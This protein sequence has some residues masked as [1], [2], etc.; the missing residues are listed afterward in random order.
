MLRRGAASRCCC[1]ATGRRSRR[2]RPLHRRSSTPRT[3][4]RGVRWDSG[5]RVRPPPPPRRLGAS[6]RGAIVGGRAG[7]GGRGGA[8]SNLAAAAPAA[9]L[10][11]GRRP[12]ASSG[13]GRRPTAAPLPG[14]A[15]RPPPPQRRRWRR[16][17]L[18]GCVH[19]ALAAV[20]RRC[21]PELQLYRAALS[22]A[23]SGSS[24]WRWRRRRGGC[25]RA[26]LRASRRRGSAALGC[27]SI[28]VELVTSSGGGGG[29]AGR[30][31][32]ATATTRRRRRRRRRAGGGCERPSS[33][34]W[35]REP[36]SAMA[37]DDLWVLSTDRRLGGPS[38]SRGRS[39]RRVVLRDARGQAA[40]R[41]PLQ[42]TLGDGG[43][44]R[45]ERRRRLGQLTCCR[46]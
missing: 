44:A 18:L 30:R 1:A 27:P 11:R 34:L 35:G 17:P 31:S 21:V 39:A 8:A 41:Q 5:R 26:S 19:P 29:G 42:R 25:C 37:V 46:T 4:R 10:C 16:S 33:R 13:R 38:S 15:R 32:G 14:A 3:P 23:V 40:R 20:A 2:R 22:A 24:T 45:A 43:G 36:A 6:L 7:R 12:A 9:R 28:G